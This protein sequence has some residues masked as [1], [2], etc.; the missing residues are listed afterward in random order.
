MLGW[1]PRY[2]VIF[3][4][5]ICGD[6]AIDPIE[7]GRCFDRHAGVLVLLARQWCNAAED[8]VQEAFLKLSVARP[9]PD[10]PAAWLYQ[11]VRNAAISQG[12]SERRRAQHE[13]RHRQDHP[14]WFV[15]DPAQQ[16][17]ADAAVTAL[18][19][20]PTEEREVVIAHLWGGLT[21]EEIAQVLSTSSSSAHR[22]YSKGLAQLRSLLGEVHVP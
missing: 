5:A 21:F 22:L 20:L 15:H 8:V 19:K 10:N 14:D 9:T 2:S 13:G 12:R 11:V 4:A 7:L 6:N 16:I 3:I 18:M 1:L 17:D